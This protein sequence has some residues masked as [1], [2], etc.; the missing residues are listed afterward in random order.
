MM[1]IAVIRRLRG[2]G[3][4]KEGKE[5][6]SSRRHMLAVPDACTLGNDLLHYLELK[7]SR[8]LHQNFK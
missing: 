3:K 8:N 6:A 5:P 4:A 1:F 2:G 7:C